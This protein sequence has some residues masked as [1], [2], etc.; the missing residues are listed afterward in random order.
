MPIDVIYVKPVLLPKS[1]A[2]D[3]EVEALVEKKVEVND[4]QDIQQIEDIEFSYE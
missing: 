2:E 4:V 1:Q 3:S